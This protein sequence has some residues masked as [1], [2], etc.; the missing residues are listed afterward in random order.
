MVDE[1]SKIS[2]LELSMFI[3]TYDYINYNMR[4]VFTWCVCDVTKKLLKFYF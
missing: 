2:Y 3:A 1:V 4:Y